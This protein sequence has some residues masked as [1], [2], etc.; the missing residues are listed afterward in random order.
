MEL[1]SILLSLFSIPIIGNLLSGMLLHKFIKVDFDSYGFGDGVLLDF[2]PERTLEDYQDNGRI[3]K[4]NKS[5]HISFENMADKGSIKI[6]P[7][8]FIRLKSRFKLPDNTIS[9][10][11]PKDGIGGGGLPRYFY[12][13]LSGKSQQI[14]CASYIDSEFT[15]YLDEGQVPSLPNAKRREFEFFSLTPDDT[16]VIILD[17]VAEN[18]Y[19][20][21]FDVGIPIKIRGKERIIWSKKDFVIAIPLT[22]TYY[23]SSKIVPY[24]DSNPDWG[25]TSEGFE[26]YPLSPWFDQVQARDNWVGADYPDQEWVSFLNNLCVRYG[27][28]EFRERPERIAWNSYRE[29]E[30]LE[31]I[32]VY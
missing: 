22:S 14:V 3:L 12:G 7:F 27:Y 18:G 16:E 20:Y 10:V 2:S 17:I 6:A 26:K 5:I 23:R 19:Y 24:S 29:R 25:D 30:I 8:A 21:E 13:S 32:N 9:Y 4:S 11:S 1:A 15:L 28:S 31:R